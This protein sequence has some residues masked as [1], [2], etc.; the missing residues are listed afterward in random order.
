MCKDDARIYCF[1]FT[2]AAEP[3]APITELG[4]LMASFPVAP[5]YA[6]MLALGKQHNLLPYVVLLV[7]ALSVQEVCLTES[8]AQVTSN[9]SSHHTFLTASPTARE[10]NLTAVRAADCTLL[11][12]YPGDRRLDSRWASLQ[13]V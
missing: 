12:L 9:H 6:K 2:A 5:R 7:A 8:H 1:F 4:R 3:E 11:C 13:M 10:L